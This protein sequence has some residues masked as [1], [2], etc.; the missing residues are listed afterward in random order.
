MKRKLDD[1][2]ADVEDNDQNSLP[3]ADAPTPPRKKS[4]KSRSKKHKARK[5]DGIPESDSNAAREAV[6]MAEQNAI[7]QEQG[8]AGQV[9]SHVVEDAGPVAEGETGEGRKKKQK[10]KKKSSVD[11]QQPGNAADSETAA[12]D[13]VPPDQNE[14]RVADDVNA[15]EA[16]NQPEAKAGRQTRFIAFVGSWLRGLRLGSRPST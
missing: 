14:A 5:A 6:D 16:Q 12:Q 2:F 15:E 9:E 3:D 8:T 7:V 10:K 13:A 11:V 4:K 1:G